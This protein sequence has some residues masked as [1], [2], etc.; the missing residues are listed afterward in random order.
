[1]GDTMMGTDS[2]QGKRAEGGKWNGG[3]KDLQS[4]RIV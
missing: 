3:E 1:M 4:P 2:F